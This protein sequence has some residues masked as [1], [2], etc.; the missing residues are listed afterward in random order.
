M[1]YVLP[2][3]KEPQQNL[4]TDE[5]SIHK[6]E[7]YCSANELKATLHERGFRL[8]VQRQKILSIF[9]TLTQGH[10][11][12]AEDLYTILRQKDERISLSTVYRTLNLMAKIGLIRE[13]E[14]AEGHKHYE[15]NQPSSHQHHHL[16]CLQ[17]NRILEFK[18]DLVAKMGFRQTES[19]GYQLLDCQLTL[20]VICLEAFGQDWQTL[21]ADW[22][23]DRLMQPHPLV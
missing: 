8:T 12:S 22:V 9:Q 17:C 4:Q 15:L 3:L 2:M 7:A 20:R 21:P 14:F 23:C 10:H 19:C 16:V 5:R 18:N 13:L 11:L 1:I 6:I